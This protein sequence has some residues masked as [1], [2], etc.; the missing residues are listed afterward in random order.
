MP[1]LAQMVANCDAASYYSQTK[2]IYAKLEEAGFEVY[3]AV[4][5]ENSGF[6]IKFDETSLTLTVGQANQE[7]TLPADFS[8]MVH[9]AE[10]LTSSENWHEINP[11]EDLESVVANQLSNSG[12]ISLNFGSDSQYTYYGPYLDSADSQAAAAAQLQKIR[13]APIP[14]AP[15]FVQIVY[16][17]KWLPIVNQNSILMLPSEGTYAM[18]AKATAKLLRLNNDSLS[19]EFEQVGQALETKF[20]SWVR[21]RQIQQMPTAQPFMSGTF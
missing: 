3:T 8:Q 4:L 14:D 12:L 13:I 16:S 7:Y 20:L 15:R 21:N 2:S 6:F 5:K 9:L 19:M 17:A 11:A 18:E 1:N 10:R